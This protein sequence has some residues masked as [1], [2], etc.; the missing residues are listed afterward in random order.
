MMPGIRP[1][2]LGSITYEDW[3]K[4]VR[5]YYACDTDVMLLCDFLEAAREELQIRRQS[6]ISKEA[7]D[8]GDRSEDEW[9]T[10]G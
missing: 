9:S 10:G 8:S 5:R 2:S 7:S 4:A 6:G 1:V 3:F